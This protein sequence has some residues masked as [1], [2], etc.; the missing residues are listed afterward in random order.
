[1]RY[2]F[3]FACSDRLITRSIQPKGFL[4]GLGYGGGIR[5]GGLICGDKLAKEKLLLGRAIASCVQL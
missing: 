3:E 1:M 5:S 2:V 4:F